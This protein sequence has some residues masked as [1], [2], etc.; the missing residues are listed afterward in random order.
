MHVNTYKLYGS[1]HKINTLLWVV[2]I[3]IC[4]AQHPVHKT[5]S[6]CCM[7]G[8][9]NVVL[10]MHATWCY[11]LYYKIQF[12]GKKGPPMFTRVPFWETEWFWVEVRIFLRNFLKKRIKQQ[13]VYNDHFERKCANQVTNCNRAAWYTTDASLFQYLCMQYIIWQRSAQMTTNTS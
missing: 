12:T 4:V 6:G 11:P 2:C 5:D 3:P 7:L 8:Q 10:S 9:G 1:V 13:W